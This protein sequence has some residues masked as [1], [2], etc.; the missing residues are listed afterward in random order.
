VKASGDRPVA[1]DTAEPIAPADP[2]GGRI[3]AYSG[4]WLESATVL[5]RDAARAWAGEFRAAPTKAPGEICPEQTAIP[6]A[7]MPHLV[8]IFDGNSGQTRIWADSGLSRGCN[9][10]TN[11]Q[12]QTVDL[13]P[14]LST[15]LADAIR[16]SLPGG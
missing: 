2:A 13:T 10:A 4:G 3:C 1:R 6:W 14:G 15:A 9:V 12:G 7:T 11:D 8:V 5:D 16:D